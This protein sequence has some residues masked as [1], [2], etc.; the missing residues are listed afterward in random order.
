M[1]K[2]CKNLAVLVFLLI[3]FILFFTSK[4]VFGENGSHGLKWA[5]NI[6]DSVRDAKMPGAKLEEILGL[7]DSNGEITK[8]EDTNEW[9][10]YYYIES[11]DGFDGLG[12]TVYYDGSTFSWDP[13]GTLHNFG[14]PEYQNAVNWVNKSDNAISDKTFSYRSIQVFADYEDNYENA[15]NLVYVYYNASD[16]EMVAYVLLNADTAGILLVEMNP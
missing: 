1:N 7:V 11:N 16:S 9:T 2:D 12:V 8:S 13:G 5:L 10:F 6:A 4:K 15:N 3:G 14:I